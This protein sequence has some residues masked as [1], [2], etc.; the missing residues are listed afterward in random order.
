MTPPPIAPAA[1]PIAPPDSALARPRPDTG[2]QATG[3]AALLDAPPASLPPTSA[4]SASLPTARG[5]AA[6]AGAAQA[7]AGLA[8][9]GASGAQLLETK[10]RLAAGLRQLE[11]EVKAAAAAAARTGGPPAAEAV[12]RGAAQALGALLGAADAAAGTNTVALLRQAA[13]ATDQPAATGP[14]D[15]PAAGTDPAAQIEALFG[16]LFQTLGLVRAAAS[17]ALSPAPAGAD[18]VPPA[19]GAKGAGTGAGTAP[20]QADPSLARLLE[21]AAAA[22]A[23]AE[24]GAGPLAGT[25]A[26]AAPD[27]AAEARAAAGHSRAD[28]LIGGARA[29]V[30][31]NGAA[32]QGAVTPAGQGAGQGAGPATG[33]AA[34][35]A[36][37][38][39][40]P[41]AQKAPD[42]FGLLPAGLTQAAA[43]PAGPLA[44]AGGAPAAG[45]APGT[46][47]Q[48][49]GDGPPARLA[50]FVAGQI[51]GARLDGEGMR[52]ALKPRGLGE[53]QLEMQ[54]DDSG[55]L[56]V[57]VRAENPMVLAAL[58]GDQD[59]LAAL[60]SRT[61]APAA[62]LSFDFQ[63]LGGQDRSRQQTPARPRG[64]A[65]GL[66]AVAADEDGETAGW[67]QTI[68]R[69]R[70]DIRT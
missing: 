49:P 27:R 14:A 52:I 66:G 26:G 39:A 46:A 54:R 42:F 2:A 3:F 64:G 11:A 31:A 58:R 25:Q 60:L 15:H 56:Q 63:D 8:R 36:P 30:P 70:L 17:P 9:A 51:L 44:T 18:P 10:V 34:A 33:P 48:Q 43:P 13:D 7:G 22:G 61:G 21:A 1:P 37:G 4:L 40:R 16:W 53:V 65:T 41:E 29:Q 5:A 28:G 32:G 57:V 55:R 69:G 45:A 12:A 6:Q 67:R 68:G 19:E 35:Q 20:P 62:G 38:H 47:L 50:G 24:A 23:A 59:H